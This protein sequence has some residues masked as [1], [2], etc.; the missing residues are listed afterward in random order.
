[1]KASAE[2]DIT[3]A[4]HH[5]AANAFHARLEDECQLFVAPTS[6]GGGKSAMPVG[7]VV[8]LAVVEARR[9]G[10]GFVFLWDNVRLGYR[11][12]EG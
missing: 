2:R 3:T 7:S 9:F 11:G 6:V 1:M 10:S 12:A 8:S 4:S 5:L